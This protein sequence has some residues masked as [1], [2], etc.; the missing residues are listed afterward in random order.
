V[1]IP[2]R[3][4]PFV[5]IGFQYIPLTQIDAS[6]DVCMPDGYSGY[7]RRDGRGTHAASSVDF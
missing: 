6:T 1:G 5:Y 2:H 7:R 4:D 3:F